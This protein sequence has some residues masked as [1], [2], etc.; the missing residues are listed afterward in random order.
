MGIHLVN[1]LLEAGHDVTIATRGN[2]PDSF[3]DKVKR[4]K[5]NRQDP[6]SL[7]DAFKDKSYDVTIDNIAY[8]SN[9]VRHLLESL[10][11]GKYIL[12]STVSVYSSHFHE[13]MHESEVDTK[14]LPLKWCNYEDVTYDEA[15][16]QAEA[17]LFQAYPSL[18]SAAV[19]F[20]YIFGE[21]DY[22]KRLYFY[23]QH[24]CCQQAM[25]VDNLAA[26]LSFINSREA[27]KFLFHAATTPV[28]GYVN[29][30]SGGTISLDEIIT[31]TEKQSGKKAIIHESGEAATLNGVP[32]FGLDTSAASST[33]F[34]FMN[35]TDWVYPLIDKWISSISN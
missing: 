35:I 9:D 10:N 29:A 24:I 2:T 14:T 18:P 1:L 33:G 12:T 17:A 6:D 27:G 25:H 16:R 11:T 32:S 23:V 19:R 26:R 34:N 31:Y 30:G 20:P 7:R 5:I 3:G 28:Y 8:A 13:N 21:D 22:T 4:L 15:K